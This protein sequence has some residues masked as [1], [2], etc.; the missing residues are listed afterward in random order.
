MYNKTILNFLCIQPKDI[1][2]D[3]ITT[4]LVL[5]ISVCYHARLENRK[6]FEKF[7]VK[8]FHDST[9]FSNLSDMEFKSIIRKLVKHYLY[10]Q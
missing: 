3:E 9:S 8:M 10:C 6:P 2:T 1:K 5:S 7:I 4:S